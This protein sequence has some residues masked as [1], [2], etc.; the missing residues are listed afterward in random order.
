M[1]VS[2]FYFFCSSFV[3]LHFFPIFMRLFFSEKYHLNFAEK[4]LRRNSDFL[5]KVK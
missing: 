3:Y 2:G 4:R 5:A 1:F